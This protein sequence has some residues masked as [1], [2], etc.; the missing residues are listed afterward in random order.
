MKSLWKKGLYRSP[1]QYLIDGTIREFDI[2]KA[3]ISVLRDANVLSESEYQYFLTCDKLER[4]VAIGKM[5]GRDKN[6]TN[7]LKQGI[8]NA[9]QA[10]MQL[11][12]IDD[13]D[14]LSIRNDAITIIGNKPVKTLSITDRVAFRQTGL[15]TSF[16]SIHYLEFF[17]YAN[18]ITDTE[19]L[20]IK[21]LG[22]DA[23]PLH[24]DFM[25]DLLSELFYNAQIRGIEEAISVLRNVYDNYI[26]M[27]FP[28][29][30]YRELNST[31][32][33]KLMNMTSCKCIY[34][35]HLCEYQKRYVDISYN[36]SILRTLMQIFSSVYYGTGKYQS[37]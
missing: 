17:Y 29:E 33:Y 23:V 32:R 9:R 3:N 7:V 2:S 12:D 15:Y 35:D 6:V 26:T 27:K 37:P 21:G 14:I 28:I 31:S 13:S 24:T 30:Y 19:Y 1:I 36:A 5:Q 20:D 4:E 11:N 18:M 22:D 34:A 10:F 8:Q 16:Y 25:L